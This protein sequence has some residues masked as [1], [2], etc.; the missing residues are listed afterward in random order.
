MRWIYA[1]LCITWGSS[2]SQ[3]TPLIRTALYVIHFWRFTFTISNDVYVCMCDVYV[4][5]Y[6]G[7]G[8]RDR[9]AG[10][11]EWGGIE[12]MS[13]LYNRHGN[14]VLPQASSQLTS[15]SERPA[16]MRWDFIPSVCPAV[17]WE[18]F[19]NRMMQHSKWPQGLLP[20]TLNQKLLMLSDGCLAVF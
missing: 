18:H 17:T 12:Q 20:S 3:C 6:T 7:R 10:R 4:C 13:V 19:P 15:T 1:D 16:F 8:D 5:L 9:Q 11:W 14:R 2:V